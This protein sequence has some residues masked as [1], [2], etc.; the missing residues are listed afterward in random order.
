MTVNPVSIYSNYDLGSNVSQDRDFSRSAMNAQVS[1]QTIGLQL[2]KLGISLSA[3]NISFANEPA[4]AI[5]QDFAREIE[6]QFLTQHVGPFQPRG[7][8]AQNA[9]MQ[10]LGASAYAMEQGRCR[11]VAPMINTQV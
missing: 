5:L 9:T 2:G 3:Q 6:L 10:R 11:Y 4:P 7:A 8:F 1:T